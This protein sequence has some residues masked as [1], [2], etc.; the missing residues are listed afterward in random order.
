MIKSGNFAFRFDGVVYI[1]IGTIWELSE[2]LLVKWS[3]AAITKKKILSRTFVSLA[4]CLSVS[5]LIMFDPFP[6]TLQ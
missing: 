1:V 2:L 5:L 4:R 3:V 6:L